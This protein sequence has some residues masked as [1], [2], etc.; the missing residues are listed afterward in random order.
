MNKSFDP[1]KFLDLYVDPQAKEILSDKLFDLLSQ[2]LSIRTLELLPESKLVDIDS[3]ETLFAMAQEE[4]P[5]YDQKVKEFLADFKDQY[6]KE[7]GVK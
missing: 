5:N 1:L 6:K 7:R 4:I 2:Y 3:L